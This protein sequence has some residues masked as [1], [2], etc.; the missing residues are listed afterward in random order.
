MVE[1][2]F[3]VSTAL[4]KNSVDIWAGT[5]KSGRRVSY[6]QEPVKVLKLHNVDE[7]FAMESVAKSMGVQTKPPPL[8]LTP[9]TADAFKRAGIPPTAIQKRSEVS[10]QELNLHPDRRAL[11]HQEYERRRHDGY[12][13]VK[14][15][16]EE[17]IKNAKNG[18]VTNADVLV[19]GLDPDMPAIPLQCIFPTCGNVDRCA[20]ILRQKNGSLR[21]GRSCSVGRTARSK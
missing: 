4:R 18:K 21:R 3:A 13:R 20:K 6:A 17:T 19:S 1:E 15:A 16:R 5:G 9:R 12:A 14:A 10:F 7:V 8:L 11:R 2:H